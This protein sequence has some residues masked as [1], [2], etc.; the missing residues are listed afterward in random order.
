M[1]L[2]GMLDSNPSIH[3]TL[4]VRPEQTIPGPERVLSPACQGSVTLG[5][6]GARG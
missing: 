4:T 5:T 6:R 3:N 2:T 1:L